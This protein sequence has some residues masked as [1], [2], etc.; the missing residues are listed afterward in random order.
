MHLFTGSS[1]HSCTFPWMQ[2]YKGQ[3]T[4]IVSGI[5]DTLPIKCYM[6]KTHPALVLALNFHK[7]SSIHLPCTVSCGMTLPP[8]HSCYICQQVRKIQSGAWSA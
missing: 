8:P 6:G 5:R 3:P 4:E 1:T 2:E 7:A